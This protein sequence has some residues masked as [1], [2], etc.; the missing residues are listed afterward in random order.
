MPDEKKTTDD[1]TPPQALSSWLS[2]I[3]C[4]AVSV[5]ALQIFNQN[6][7]SK[8]DLAYSE[9]KQEVRANHVESIIIRGDEIFGDYRNIDEENNKHFKTLMPPFPDAELIPLLDE[10]EVIVKVQ[11]T[12]TSPWIMFLI[13]LLPWVFL[14]SLF[15]FG[16]QILSKQLMPGADSG[17]TKSKARLAEA[18]DIK[19]RYDD[20]AGL[21]NAKADLWEVIEFLRSPAKYKKIGAKI[22]KGI[23]LMGP[24]GTGKTLLAKA[25]AGEAGVPFFSITGSEFVE[26]FVGVGASRVRDMFIQ[27]RAAAPSL[28]FIDEIDSVGRAR[29]GAFGSNNDEREQTLNQILAEM[30]LSLIHI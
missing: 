17:F 1:K 28:I 10:K 30:D 19:T 13:N 15:V 27:A 3:L 8:I 25:T 7:N 9:F 16:R 24:P 29:S 4:V 14:V 5:T 12:E 18:Q 22:P 2:A 6:E 21:N 26:M 11:S 23:L 20:I